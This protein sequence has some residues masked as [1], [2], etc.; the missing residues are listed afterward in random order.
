[1]IG[2]QRV[3]GVLGGMGPLAT[4]DFMQKVIKATPANRDQEHVPMIVHAIP[5]IPD[6]ATAILSGKDDPFPALLEG[7][8]TLERSGAGLVVIPCNSA[9]AWF[10]RLS[11]MTSMQMLHIADA[12]R[13]ALAHKGGQLALMATEGTVRAGFYQRYLSEADRKVLLPPPEVQAMIT[14]GIASV[15]AGDI[16]EARRLIGDAAHALQALGAERLLLACTELPIAIEETEHEAMTLDATLLLARAC[17]HWACGT[18]V[19]TGSGCPDTWA[20]QE[21][22]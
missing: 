13:R 4:V 9:H 16:D 7:L 11:A 21:V 14:S 18:S 6:R 2:T 17:V 12:V 10:D 20:G 8:K 5:Q 22:A 15:K 19:T 1:M 3:V